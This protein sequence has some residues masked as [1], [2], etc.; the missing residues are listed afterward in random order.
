[1]NRFASKKV[2]KKAV[3]DDINIIILFV[4]RRIEDGEK[5]C[6]DLIALGELTLINIRLGIMNRP[7]VRCLHL[8]LKGELL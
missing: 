6:K 4:F 2:N 8:T 1:M 5:L 7:T 3:E